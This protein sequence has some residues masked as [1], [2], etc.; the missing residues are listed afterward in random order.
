[1]IRWLLLAVCLLLGAAPAH[2][3]ATIKLSQQVF[4]GTAISAAFAVPATYATVQL[5]CFGL[6]TDSTDA[7]G[8]V[9]IQIG[10]GGGPT[11]DTT[12]ADYEWAAAYAYDG[13]A[14]S[15]TTTQAVL[16]VQIMG[17]VGGVVIGH[18]PFQAAGAANDSFTITFFNVNSSSLRK[19]YNWSGYEYF[20]KSGIGYNITNA[21][22]GT[23]TANTAALTGLLI[24]SNG[25]DL[26][27]TGTCTL[28]GIL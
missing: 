14:L 16:A 4:S 9:L 25:T 5:D 17:L 20:G 18:E 19:V 21:G 3:Q 10:T 12:P 2:A 23:F 27:E 11:Y 13:T 8:Y 28:Y 6:T 15:P 7:N 26:L 1:M 22:G 24:T